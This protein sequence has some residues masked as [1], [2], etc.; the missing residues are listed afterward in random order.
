MIADEVVHVILDLVDLFDARDF[1]LI[2]LLCF[3][4]ALVKSKQKMWRKRGQA[5][6]GHGSTFRSIRSLII[7][8]PKPL[9]ILVL[10]PG[11]PS[12]VLVVVVLLHPLAVC[13]LFL[14]IGGEVVIFVFGLLFRRLGF[15]HSGCVLE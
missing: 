5:K 12:L 9:E 8:L 2:E 15:A 14:L 13:L 10:D 4:P 3:C 6:E 11:H 1:R 7:S